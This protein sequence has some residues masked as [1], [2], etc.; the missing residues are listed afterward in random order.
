MLSPISCLPPPVQPRSS[1]QPRPSSAEGEPRLETLSHWTRAGGQTRVVGSSST[2]PLLPSRWNDLTLRDFKFN[3]STL[4]HPCA[5][6][7]GGVYV[8]AAVLVDEAV[9]WE[10]VETLCEVVCVL[11]VQGSVTAGDTPAPVLAVLAGA[12]PAAP[13]EDRKEEK[14][15]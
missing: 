9:D 6:L 11:E 2:T 13:G 10:L 4:S 7:G 15:E 8:E 3:D 12:T 5:E 14:R 1:R